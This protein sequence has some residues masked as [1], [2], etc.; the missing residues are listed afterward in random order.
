MIVS[1]T[2]QSRLAVASAVVPLPILITSIYTTLSLVCLFPFRSFVTNITI[3]MSSLVISL[4]CHYYDYD[5][6]RWH[7][8]LK[9]RFGRWLTGFPEQDQC[10]MCALASES[11]RSFSTEGTRRSPLFRY[12]GPPGGFYRIVFG[13]LTESASIE[14]RDKCCST[15]KCRILCGQKLPNLKRRKDVTRN[16]L[17]IYVL[18]PKPPNKHPDNHTASENQT[19]I[20]SR[21]LRSRQHL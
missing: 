15:I 1:T 7:L 11:Q 8:S 16:L 17:V 3:T 4:V 12:Q 18:Y 20:P 2:V 10:L 21:F 5:C 9:F 13:K 6:Y 14:P 19:K